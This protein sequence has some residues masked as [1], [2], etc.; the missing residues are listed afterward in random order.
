MDVLV[1]EV[2][3]CSGQSNMEF[4]L[5]GAANGDEGNRHLGQP[6]FLRHFQVTKDGRSLPRLDTLQGHWELSGPR[7]GRRLHGGGLLFRQ[8]QVQAVIHQPVRSDPLVPGAAHP[9]EAWTSEE[10]FRRP[11]PTRS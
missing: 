4:Q 8:G 6:V 5:K 10:G 1:G 3:L 11:V 2:W 9:S 7:D